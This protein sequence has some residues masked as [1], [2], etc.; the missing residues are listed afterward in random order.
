MWKVTTFI[1][2]NIVTA[3]IMWKGLWL[4]NMHA[5]YRVRGKCSVKF[6]AGTTSGSTGSLCPNGH[7]VAFKAI[8]LSIVGG[9]FTNCTE[10]TLSTVSI[11]S[12]GYS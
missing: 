6:H 1:G 10:D 9:K 3:Q 11:A 8:L 4:M 7:L 5:W 2:N 12:G